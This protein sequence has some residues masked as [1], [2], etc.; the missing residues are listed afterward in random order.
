MTLKRWVTTQLL[1]I[2]FEVAQERLHLTISPINMDGALRLLQP[3][4]TI[5][6]ERPICNFSNPLE[7]LSD[8]ECLS[9]YRFR[10]ESVVIIADAVATTCDDA[11][12]PPT[13]R[14]LPVIFQVLL[15]LRFFD[16]G[17]FQSVIG[18]TLNL[19][20]STVCRAVKRVAAALCT[21]LD[22]WVKMPSREEPVCRKQDLFSLAGK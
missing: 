8:E 5:R 11:D 1:R 3:W 13:S 15:A 7:S 19:S 22:I 20:K 14:R 9:K 16:S 18:D 6:I 4:R 12:D 10:R 17:A 21:Q 2:P